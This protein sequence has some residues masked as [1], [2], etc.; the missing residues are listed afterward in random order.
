LFFIVVAGL[1]I[2]MTETLRR[3]MLEAESARLKVDAALGQGNVGAWEVALDTQMV[4][5]SASA[6]AMF[7]LPYTGRSSPIDRW[8]S[9]VDPLDLPAVR[10][11]FAAARRSTSGFMAEFRVFKEDGGCIWIMARGGLLA[12]GTKRLMGAFVDVTDRHDAE[13]RFRDT[14][15]LLRTIADTAPVLI[16]AKDLQGQMLLAN[17]PVLKLLGKSWQDVEGRT[18]LEFLGDTAQAET[19]MAN[20]RRLMQEGRAE[21]IEEYVGQDDG[22][23]RVWS[24]AKAPLRDAA[25]KVTGLVGVST[26]VTEQKRIENRL[27]LMVDELNHRVKNTLAVAQAV[28][29]RT[30]RGVD[31]QT[32]QVLVGRLAALAA[33]HDLLTREKWEGV[34]MADVVGVVLAPYG[35][36][37]DHRFRVA[38][39]RLRISPK[40]AQALSMAFHELVTNALK[41]GAMSDQHG[42]VSVAWSVTDARRPAV[43]LGAIVPE[44]AITNDGEARFCVT[45]MERGGPA[46]APAARDG[47]GSWLLQRGL[48]HDLGGTVHLNFDDPAGVVCVIE[49]PMSE[50]AAAKMMVFP[51]VG[52]TG[53]AA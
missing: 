2:W 28:A 31:A 51:S 27:R 17:Q 49:A 15:V 48:P 11:A 7:G 39:P 13:E 8:M 6:H 47:F 14:S 23:A 24:S 43:V 12:D 40:A 25:G 37:D 32:R 19:V 45:W 38:G 30:L 36:A 1:V 33:A 42:V 20:D 44:P 9:R 34:E 22:V 10:E 46:V 35:G 50:I 3:A 16:Y 5:A 53:D 18:D 26:D 4:R 52:M 41:Y 29:V 21:Q